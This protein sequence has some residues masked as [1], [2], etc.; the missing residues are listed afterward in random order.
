MLIRSKVSTLLIPRL[1]A[2]VVLLLAVFAVAYTDPLSPG[3]LWDG[4]RLPTSTVVTVVVFGL[5]I[6]AAAVGCVKLLRKDWPILLVP[7]VMIVGAGHAGALTAVL[8]QGTAG[9]AIGIP[10]WRR[11][12]GL[13]MPSDTSLGGIIISWYIGVSV[14]AYIGWIALHW[15]INYDYVYFGF[16]LA[17][18]LL[19]R[20]PLAEVL[21]AVTEKAK[22]YRFSPGQW[23]IVVCAIILLPC[24]LTPLYLCDDAT[25]HLFFPKQIAMFGK[26]AFDPSY[27]WAVDTEVFAQSYFAAGYLLGGEYAARLSNF[28]VAFAAMLLLEG[29]CRRTFSVATALG[30]TLIVVSMPILGTAVSV[31][32]LE[33]LNFLSVAVPMIV[34]FDTLHRIAYRHVVF[35]FVMATFAYLY[36]QQSVFLVVPLTALLATALLIRSVKQRSSRPMIWFIGGSLTA[37]AL[38]SPFFVQNYVLTGNP[39]FPWLNGVFCSEWFEPGNYE[40]I[41]FDEKLNLGSLWALTFHSERFTEGGRFQFGISFFMLACFIP[42]VF[43]GGKDLLLKWIITG[44]FLASVLLWWIVTSPNLR[45]F[46]GP[47]VPGSILFG[48]TMNALWERVRVDRLATTLAG[49]A[50]AIMFS[51]NFASLLIGTEGSRPYPLFETFTKR[52]DRAMNRVGYVENV[53]KV[54]SV[55]GSKFGK[56]SSCLL[57]GSELLCLADQRVEWMHGLSYSNWQAY[58]QWK[59]EED[60]FDWIFRKRKI[61]C[62]IMPE[63]AVFPLLTSARFRQKVQVDF[64][65]AG[66]LLLV[67]K[68]DTLEC[69]TIAQTENCP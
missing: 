31:V 64:A 32:H 25:R 1:A 27:V 30:T 67:P 43:V 51:A 39:C 41:R 23:A 62:I 52:Y 29:Y 44:L 46:V 13:G 49:A 55:A 50:L 42:L 38:I 20:R 12:R 33:T 53:R 18:I 14:N 65:M 68:A 5:L 56:E 66:Y 6:A 48:L 59:N 17:E 45:Y 58:K 22:S 10:L 2:L 15:Q 9:L 63:N 26:H 3:T 19:L 11:V 21:T 54:F 24:A 28:V 8:M 40:G 60:A 16:L 57:V 47:L 35:F 69:A 36:K 34:M 4:N 37:I 61:A 7:L